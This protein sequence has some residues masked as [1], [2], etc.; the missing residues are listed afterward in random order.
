[1]AEERRGPLGVGPTVKF[2]S[3]FLTF[4]LVLGLRNKMIIFLDYL[5]KIYIKHQNSSTPIYQRPF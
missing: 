2:N 3:S 5:D 1:M 4:Q